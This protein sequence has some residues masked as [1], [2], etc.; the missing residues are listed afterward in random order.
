[1]IKIVFIIPPL[2]EL[3]DLSGPVQVF[4]EAQFYGFQIGIEFYSL[5]QDLVSAVGLPFGKLENYENAKLKEG[6]YLFIPGMNFESLEGNKKIEISFFQ[7]LSE[8]SF[9]NINIC[10]IC[11]AAFI[12]G[13]AGLLDNRKCTTHWRRIDLLKS[14]YPKAIVL[15]DVLFVKSNNIYTSAGISAGI[16]L[17][18]ELLAELKDP[19]FVNK[20]ARGLVVYYRRSSQHT[21]KSIYLDYRNHINPKIHE[22]QDFMIANI[23]RN[24]NIRKL[25]ALV[26]TSPRNLSRIFK[27]ATGITVIG[28]LTKL[29]LEK[30]IT[31]KKNPEYTID[32]IASE[33]G[34]KSPR[35]LQRILKKNY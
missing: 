4:T 31:F 25:A 3:L 15:D 33:C 27:K 21:Q 19:V 10:S 24:I 20:V 13:K 23:R 11:N 32:F 17:A 26:N 16:D 8:C 9:N 1:M 34:F 29:R 28:Y 2:V 35:Q 30:A 14:L 6:D 18:L 12:L 5:E 22:I 7:W